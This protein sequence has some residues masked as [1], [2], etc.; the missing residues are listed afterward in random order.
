M[1][2]DQIRQAG[3]LVAMTVVSLPEPAELASLAGDRSRQ[4][5]TLPRKISGAT[6]GRP[7]IPP[8]PPK[9]DPKTTL[10]VG[11]ARARSMFNNY[12]EVGEWARTGGWFRW[13]GAGW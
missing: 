12:P 4:F 8:L 13:T 5:S 2:V 6:V 10:S 7:P 3:D 11:R 9:R 1:V